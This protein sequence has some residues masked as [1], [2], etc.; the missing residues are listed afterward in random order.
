MGERL[1]LI[2]LSSFQIVRCNGARVDIIIRM[3]IVGV[4]LGQAH[5]PPRGGWGEASHSFREGGTSMDLIG[6]KLK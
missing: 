4:R 6:F 5:P 1:N 3:S 2:R